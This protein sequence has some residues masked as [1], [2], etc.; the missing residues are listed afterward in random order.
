[1]KTLKISI[2]VVALA[3]ATIGLTRRTSSSEQFATGLIAALS[4]PT[5]DHFEALLPGVDEFHTVMEQ[6]KELYGDNLGEAKQEFEDEY[7]HKFMPAVLDSYNA[8]RQKAA[9]E[10]ISWSKVSHLRVYVDED[11]T[12]DNN[13]ITIYFSADGQVRRLVVDKAVKLNGRWR[14]ADRIKLI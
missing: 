6:N 11:A 2:A 12:S 14:I 7:N 3:F 4:S 13:R 10:G 1:M 9:S 8:V 5:I